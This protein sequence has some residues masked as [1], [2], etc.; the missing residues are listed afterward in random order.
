MTVLNLFLNRDKTQL[1][2]T[3][4][5]F[6]PFHLISSA[7]KLAK[8]AN[9]SNKNVLSQKFYWISLNAKFDAELNQLKGYKSQLHF[10]VTF[11]LITFSQIF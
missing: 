8:T 6:E 2:N 1:L 10:S 4:L 5:S 11:S 7:L 3:V 9:I